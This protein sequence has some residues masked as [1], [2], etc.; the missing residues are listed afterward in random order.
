MPGSTVTPRSPGCWRVLEED[1]RDK[2]LLIDV[3][4]SRSGPLRFGRVKCLDAEA[5]AQLCTRVEPMPCS[6]GE[7]GGD[8][9]VPV[10]EAHPPAAHERTGNCWDDDDEVPSISRPPRFGCDLMP[11]SPGE[12]RGGI[13]VC[14]APA[15]KEH[16][17][18]ARG[19]AWT[20]WDDDEDSGHA[21]K[22][23]KQKTW[24]VK[25][26][27]MVR[28]MT[29]L[30]TSISRVSKGRTEQRDAEI[31]STKLKSEEGLHSCTL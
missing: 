12:L 11:C 6:P 21:G 13:P 22:V 30:A 5:F 8:I 31:R 19:Q 16:P 26:T 29:S 10:I 27:R 23:E 2:F 18:A 25:V 20:C 3:I 14:R 9:P 15:M 1:K 7:L 24:R 28:A 4:P 17:H